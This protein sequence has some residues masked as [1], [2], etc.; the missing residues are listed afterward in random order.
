VA[1]EDIGLMAVFMLSSVA[2]LD[3]VVVG[4]WINKTWL[5]DF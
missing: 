3:G 4:W 5:A 2:S 1:G